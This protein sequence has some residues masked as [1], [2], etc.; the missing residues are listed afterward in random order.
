[1]CDCG[2]LDLVTREMVMS[3]GMWLQVRDIYQS[4]EYLVL[5]TTDRQCAFD[6]VLASIPFKGQ[7]WVVVCNGVLGGF[8]TGEYDFLSVYSTFFLSLVLTIH[9]FSFLISGII[10]LCAGLPQYKT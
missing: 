1:M 2:C 8:V 5:V 6:R 7:V 9:L 3:L 4:G 10:F